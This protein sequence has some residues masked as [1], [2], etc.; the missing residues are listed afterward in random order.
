MTAASD[1][2]PTRLRELL[3]A[4]SIV[5]EASATDRAEAVRLAGTVLLDAGAVDGAYVDAMLDREN[6]V[7]TYVGEGIAVP[8]ATVGSNAEVHRDALALLRF[9]SEIDWDGERVSVVIAVAAHGRGYIGLIS[10]LAT[11]LLDPAR[12]EALRKAATVEDVYDVFA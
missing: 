3:P 10:Q 6:I 12:S 7:S 5:L 9:P 2:T 8:H 4:T 11:T 1:L